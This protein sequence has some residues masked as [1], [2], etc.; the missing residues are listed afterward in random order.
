[1]TADTISSWMMRVDEDGLDALVWLGKPVQKF[2][3]RHVIPYSAAEGI[4][5]VLSKA[6]IAAWQE[7]WHP[8]PNHMI[9]AKP[10]QPGYAWWKGYVSV[11]WGVDFKRTCSFSR[12]D[13]GVSATLG[14]GVWLLRGLSRSHCWHSRRLPAAHR[15]PRKKFA[16]V[17]QKCCSRNGQAGPGGL[18][19]LPRLPRGVLP[20]LVRLRTT[21]WPCSPTRRSLPRNA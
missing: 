7:T 9:F 2:H 19:D 8:P 11:K 14:Q 15:R 17:A 21:D 5:S 3:P 13:I 4:L 20:A 10:G 12:H 1:M 18:E 6:K 16:N